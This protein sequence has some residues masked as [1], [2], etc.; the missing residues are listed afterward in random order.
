MNASEENIV[1]D[2]QQGSDLAFVRLYNYHKHGIYLYC[3]KM[4]SDVDAAK[5]AVQDI[6]VKLYERRSQLASPTSF[7]SWLYAIARNDCLSRLRKRNGGEL[8]GED[9]PADPDLSAAELYDRKE[10][11]EIVA[12]AVTR[13]KPELREV[14]VLREYHD[15]SYQEIAEVLGTTESVVKSRLYTARRLLY[16][17]LK[18]VFH[19]RNML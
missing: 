6:F 2:F 9:A 14:I 13:L 16:Q 5:D 19:E 11:R 3:L 15:L 4:L 18:P 7:K 10:E 1:T 12:V 8:H 17:Y